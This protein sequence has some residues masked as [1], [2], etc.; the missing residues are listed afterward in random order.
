MISLQLVTLAGPKFQDDVY[1]IILPTADGNIAVYPNHMPLVSVV[2]PGVISVR[3][4]RT[5]SNEQVE[6]FAT[7][8]GV[9]EIGS[10]TIRLLV[11]EADHAD[12]IVEQ[13]AK[14]A[15]ERAKQ[16]KAEAKDEI[17]IERA[18]ALIDRQEVRLKVAE[19]RRHRKRV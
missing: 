9:V 19:L 17:E 8:G 16:L 2:I 12:D 10:D 6:H 4:K 15:L 3:R 11:D 7:N 14:E 13:E 1:E 5:D 18:N